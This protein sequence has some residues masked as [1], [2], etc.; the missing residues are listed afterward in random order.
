M[1][2]FSL[3]TFA[4]ALLSFR[5][6]A[7]DLDVDLSL[8]DGLSISTQQWYENPIVWV[9]AVLLVILFAVLVRRRAK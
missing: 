6:F 8:E 1:I 4:V 5:A 3:T 2:R 7:Q 9:G